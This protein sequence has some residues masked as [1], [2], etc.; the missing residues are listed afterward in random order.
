MLWSFKT[1][2]HLTNPEVQGSEDIYSGQM[3]YLT[4]PTKMR[5]FLRSDDTLM[6][7][8]YMHITINMYHTEII[9]LNIYVNNAC[10]LRN[11]DGHIKFSVT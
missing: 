5:N 10:T 3:G 6:L 1:L 2:A 8:G 9:C 4:M 11:S 7:N